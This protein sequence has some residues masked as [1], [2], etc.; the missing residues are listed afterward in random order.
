MKANQAYKDCEGSGIFALIL[1][2]FFEVVWE[3]TNG[4]E[5]AILERVGF[6]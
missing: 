5:G 3:E 4:V 1:V 6:L 2:R